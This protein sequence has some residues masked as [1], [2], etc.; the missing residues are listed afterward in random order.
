MGSEILNPFTVPLNRVR[1]SEPFFSLLN[2]VRNS[3]PFPSP[4][5]GVRNSEPFSFP[6]EWGQKFWTFFLPRWMGSEIVNPFPS[7]LN[8]VRNSE[9]FSY[10]V[11]WGQTFWTL[12]F[13]CWMEWGQK[14]WSLFLTFC[15]GS[16]I[17]NP[18]PSLYNGV[19]N[20]E[21]FSCLVEWGQADGVRVH[22]L[23]D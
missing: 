16:E 22:V 20:S 18:F 14:L 19:R 10:P 3:E 21:P 6:A 9:P 7:Q 11:E 5:N 8:G 4:L 2:G 13:P 15:M 1:N 12:F 23:S 17:L